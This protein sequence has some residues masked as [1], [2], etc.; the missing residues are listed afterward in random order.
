MRWIKWDDLL[1]DQF[2]LEGNETG[3]GVNLSSNI[4][5]G[6][7]VAKLQ[8]AYGEGIQNYFNDAPVDIA[9]RTNFGNPRTPIVGVALPALGVVAF[10]DLNWSDTWTSTIGYSLVDIDNTDGQ[11]EDAYHKGQYA[12]ANILY[13]PVT[14][15]IP[16]AG[17]SVGRSRKL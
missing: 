3:W 11:S 10:I 9:I 13:Y 2:D 5:L 16:G 7:H 17:G 14:N 8:V 6:R 12:L 15:V 4:K 1:R